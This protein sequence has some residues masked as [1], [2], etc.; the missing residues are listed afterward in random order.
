MLVAESLRYCVIPC[1][2]Y[3]FYLEYQS[4]VLNLKMKKFYLWAIGNCNYV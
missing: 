1:D 2:I 3:V 4:N